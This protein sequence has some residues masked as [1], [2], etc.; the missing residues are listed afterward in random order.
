MSRT[1]LSQMLNSIADRGLAWIKV[2]AVAGSVEKARALAK[3]LLSERGEAS[4]TALAREL[5]ELYTGMSTDQKLAFLQALSED[6]NP[7]AE[8]V[9]EAAA[10]YI[11]DQSP[12]ALL[13]LSRAVEPPRQELLR[14]FNMAPDGTRTLVSM[15]ELLIDHVRKVPELK[16]LEA[17]L[18]HL[19]SSWFNRGFLQIER[20]DWQSSAAVLE[21][22]IAY[23]AVHAIDGWDDLHHRVGPGRRCFAF[24]HPAL[25]DEPLIFVEVA[26]T[27]GISDAV[28]PLLDRTGPQPPETRANAAIFYSISNCQPGLR[29]V[30]FGNF[31]IKQVVSDLLA[32]LP[33]LKIFSTLSPIPGFRRWLERRVGEGKAN[34]LTQDERRAITEAAGRRGAKGAFGELL[35]RDDLLDDPAV[36][37]ALRPVLMRLCAIYLLGDGKGPTDPVARF[38]LGNGARVERINWRGDVSR[39][40]IRESFG[41]MV[42]YR[43]EMDEIEANHEA[44]ARHQT[45]ARSSTVD[46]LAQ[47]RRT[48]RRS[49]RLLSLASAS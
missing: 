16:P 23:E 37:E 35:R 9:R 39:K 33:Q 46:A 30:S 4:G 41:L 8:R 14:R 5:V 21:K 11:S 18:K 36:A 10:M 48:S 7:D 38:H 29:G 12:D 43:Y 24:F 34:L 28:Q 26:L 3:S 47:S 20:I 42:N 2:P 22:L 25:R 19:F 13:A 31:L 27:D 6:Y 17:D 45:V 1:W 32:E 49:G 44:F 15:R 40:G